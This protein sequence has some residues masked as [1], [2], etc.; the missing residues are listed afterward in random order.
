MRGVLGY[1]KYHY[2]YKE[3]KFQALYFLG[4]MFLSGLVGVIVAFAVAKGSFDLLG[5]HSL[6]PA[7]A[8]VVGY[9]G[10]DFLESLYKIILNNKKAL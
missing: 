5:L 9:A 8:V 10:G 2:S 1:M 7:L 3:I 6:T 4:M